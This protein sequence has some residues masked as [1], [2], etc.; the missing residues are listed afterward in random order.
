MKMNP[1]VVIEEQSAGGAALTWVVIVLFFLVVILLFLLLKQLKSRSTVG[2]VIP[3][4][5]KSKSAFETIRA[6]QTREFENKRIRPNALNRAAK[7]AAFVE[8]LGWVLIVLGTLIGLVTM[9]T[10]STD[11]NGETTSNF[12]TGFIYLAGSLLNGS[13]VVMISA[14]IR[15]RSE[16]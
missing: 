16:Q 4:T 1:K 10:N 14:Y 15:G 11:V 7:V 13:F 3:E 5:E 9:F 6:M 8:V 12:V 2:S